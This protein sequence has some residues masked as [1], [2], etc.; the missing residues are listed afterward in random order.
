MKIK[1]V[2]I[3]F[4]AI[5]ALPGCA[6]IEK[7]K[8]TDGLEIENQNLRARIERL[9][10]EKVREIKHVVEQKGRKLSWR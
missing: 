3:M 9:Q 8:R 1:F 4:L 6:S 10:K 2:I 5:F 7:A